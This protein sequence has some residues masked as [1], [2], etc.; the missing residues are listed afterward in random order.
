MQKLKVCLSIALLLSTVGI[1]LLAT[2]FAP[3]V[4]ALPPPCNCNLPKW[5][6]GREENGDCVQADCVIE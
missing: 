1:G 2:A 4:S 6:Y 5:E 3:P